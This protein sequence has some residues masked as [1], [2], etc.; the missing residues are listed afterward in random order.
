[1]SA[2]DAGLVV[3]WMI[4]GGAALYIGGQLIRSDPAVFGPIALVVLGLSLLT[5]LIRWHQR[6]MRRVRKLPE[7]SL[8]E[9]GRLFPG[10]EEIVRERHEVK[11]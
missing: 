8:S 10:A 4:L 3:G 7:A 1:M 2:D 9:A 6:A 11:R 5:L